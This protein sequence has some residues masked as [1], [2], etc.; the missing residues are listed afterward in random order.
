MKKPYLFHFVLFVL[1]L[2]LGCEKVSF[3]PNPRY[4]KST[5]TTRQQMSA[6]RF[7]Q[8]WAWSSSVEIEQ[9]TFHFK[10][11]FYRRLG[12]VVPVTYID[13]YLGDT[14]YTEHV[15]DWDFIH[16]RTRDRLCSAYSSIMFNQDSTM[17]RKLQSMK[18][19]LTVKRYNLPDTLVYYF[20]PL[21]DSLF[22]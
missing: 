21:T 13:A 18:L 14:I 15:T 6:I 11:T 7:V 22:N 20:Y 16:E 8:Y 4:L 2:C 3:D 19:D 12:E 10:N 9:N 5:I 1:L 17:L